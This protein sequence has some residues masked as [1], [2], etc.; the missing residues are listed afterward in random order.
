MLPLSLLRAATGSPLLV[1]LKDGTTY[2]GRLGTCDAWMNMNLTD[3]ICTSATGERFWKLPSCYIRGSAIK[4]L[5]LSD[6]A[7][8]KA[9]EDEKELAQRSP[10]G[11]G[12]GR[13]RGRFDNSAGRGGRG[14]GRSGPSTGRGGGAGRGR[15]SA[16]RGRSGGRGPATQTSSS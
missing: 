8:E 13:G 2:N 10:A 4:Y 11:R 15:T 6:A 1:E 5:R 9:V 12:G 16:G 3:V 14:R 7:L